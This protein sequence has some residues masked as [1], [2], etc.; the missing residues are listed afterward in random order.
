[1]SHKLDPIHLFCKQKAI[2][3]S[4]KT[5]KDPEKGHGKS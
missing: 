4:W 5:L 1:M 2:F 3:R